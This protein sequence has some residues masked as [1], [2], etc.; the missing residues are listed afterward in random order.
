[1][2]LTGLA[3]IFFAVGSLAMQ[4]A[5]AATA[6]Q[7]LLWAIIYSKGP[8]DEPT[9]P[10]SAATTHS[11]DPADEARDSALVRTYRSGARR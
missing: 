11:D 8:T 6:V 4:F 10:T 1:M 2:M 3:L 5:T 9:T 7:M